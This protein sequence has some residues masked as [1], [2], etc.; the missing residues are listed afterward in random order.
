MSRRKNVGNVIVSGVSPQKSYE[1][2]LSALKTVGLKLD[3]EETQCL[4]QLLQQAIA[5]GSDWN[6]LNITGYRS[7]NQVTVTYYKPV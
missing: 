6:Y 3:K 7:N 5:V 2:D 4:I 1:K